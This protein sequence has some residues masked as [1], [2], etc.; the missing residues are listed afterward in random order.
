MAFMVV[1]VLI[2][3]HSIIEYKRREKSLGKVKKIIDG[4]IDKAVNKN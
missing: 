3:V 4:I 1:L 2:F